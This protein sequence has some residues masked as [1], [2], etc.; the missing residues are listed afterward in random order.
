MPPVAQDSTIEKLLQALQSLTQAQT[1]T[2]ALVIVI[3]FLGV[4]ALLAVLGYLI[5]R[6]RTKVVIPS[7]STK[8]E[9]IVSEREYMGIILSTLSERLEHLNTQNLNLNARLEQSIAAGGVVAPA[10]DRFTTSAQQ[11]P[12]HI[13]KRLDEMESTRKQL[14]ADMSTVN[15]NINK[16]TECEQELVSKVSEA[17]A[18]LDRLEKKVDSNLERVISLE[19]AFRDFQA[20]ARPPTQPVST[21]HI[22][23]A[24]P[25]TTESNPQPTKE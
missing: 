15:N 18:K 22:K 19:A 25:G 3:A 2:L 16:L 9:Q 12:G 21:V 7:T 1:D 8:P 13:D 20:A 10:L 24:A 6:G 23:P 4:I 17:L 14:G 5:W 11:L